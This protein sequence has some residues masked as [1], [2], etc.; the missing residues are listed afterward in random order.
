MPDQNRRDLA[1]WRLGIETGRPQAPSP[2]AEPAPLDLSGDRLDAPL[3]VVTAE[4]LGWAIIA[5]YA[6][7]TRLGA[8]GLRPL[9]SIEAS[10]ALFARDI[11]SRGITLLSENPRASG[12]LDPLRAGIFIALGASDFGARIVAAIFGLLLIGAALAMRRH[13]GRAGALAFAAMLTL[14]PTITYF[15]RSTSATMPA[16][17]L[18]V[19]AIALMFALAGSSNITKIVGLA[20]AIAMALSAEPTAFVV[21]AMLIAILLLMGLWE[22]IFTRH[23][24]IRLRVWWE[25]H[26]AQAIFC[27]AL[28][29]GIFLA[30]ESAFGRRNLMLPLS[31]G[32]IDWLPVQH[33][34]WR[35]GIDFYL[36][37]LA[38]YDFMIV[39]FGALGLLA[40]VAF[41]L[42]SRIA[43]VAF[44]WTI[45]SALGFLANPIRHPEWATMMIVPAALLGASFIDRI[46]RTDAWLIV[47]YPIAVLVLLTV[48]IQLAANFV[49]VAPDS[50]EAAWSHHM[51]LY[52]TE[53]ATT[54]RA[55]QE[56]YHAQRAVTDRASVFFPERSD[57]ARWYLR[58]L[59]LAATASDADV[60]V[61]P[62]NFE[63]PP[64]SIES[65]A[66]TLN[67][68]WNP[69][70]VGLMPDAAM[71]YFFTQRAWSDVKDTEVRVD[72]RNRATPAPPSATST[73]ALSETPTAEASLTPTP[74][75]TATAT[76]AESSTP[77]AT[78]SP[79][80]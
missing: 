60:V 9:N 55:E 53:P 38:F 76:V 57:V 79:A 42:R 64:N 43:A 2:G 69:A 46:H 63:G 25:R 24:M 45:L 77:T 34:A 35:G 3:Y 37:A 67:E 39:L 68:S 59:P 11:A 15:S 52:W 28:A 21:A 5:L 58:D 73:P 47:R 16:I 4:H 14:S 78:P 51:L 30:F 75:P 50:S 56:F 70:L 27:A 48:Y 66:F 10:D 29:I 31:L 54:M 22:L 65:Y 32:A 26:S 41:Q 72:I 33:P 1:E 40:F 62:P 18:V 20:I 74:M 13:L 44:L 6:L 80:P 71:R 49:R 12:W 23:P 8:L 7:I 61:A 36:P 19:L 17:A